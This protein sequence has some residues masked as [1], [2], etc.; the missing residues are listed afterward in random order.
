MEHERNLLLHVFGIFSRM[1]LGLTD[2]NFILNINL[3]LLLSLSSI[4][5]AP[6]IFFFALLDQN[7]EKGKY[8]NLQKLKNLT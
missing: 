2:S 6:I 7:P 1:F 5:I 8:Q 4:L 3:D